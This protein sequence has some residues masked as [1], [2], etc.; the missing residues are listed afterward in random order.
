VNYL[1][2]GWVDFGDARKVWGDKKAEEKMR[3]AFQNLIPLGKV[4]SLEDMNELFLFLID[5]KKSGFIT[6]AVFSVCGGQTI[7]KL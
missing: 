5:P 6:G 7:S 3:Y 2:T 4:A 1:E